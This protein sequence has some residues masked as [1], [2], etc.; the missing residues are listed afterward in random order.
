MP[1][2]QLDSIALSSKVGVPEPVRQGQERRVQASGA[3][4][5]PIR[6]RPAAGAFHGVIQDTETAHTQ[7]TGPKKRALQQRRPETKG[8]RE[9]W[10]CEQ[11][12][13]RAAFALPESRPVSAPRAPIPLWLGKEQLR[14]MGPSVPWDWVD[15]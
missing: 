9:S 14:E 4:A 1:P 11:R 3:S 6:Q 15:R 7:T 5:R 13:P 12:R 8:D 10:S 2:L